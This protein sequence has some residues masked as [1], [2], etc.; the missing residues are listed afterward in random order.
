MTRPAIVI[1][2]LLVALS[3]TRP[4]HAQNA[5]EAAIARGV[6]LRKQGKNAEALT[7]FQR[8]LSMK[9]TPRAQAQV[10]LA[11]QAL[12]AW[13][14][15]EGGLMRALERRDDAWIAHNLEP[16]SAALDLIREHLASVRIETNL[17]GAALFVNGRAVGTSPLIAAVRVVAGE[18]ELLAQ[19][20]GHGDAHTVLRLKAG[21]EQLV[22]LELPALAAAARATPQA[23]RL[24]AATA[25]TNQVAQAAAPTPAANRTDTQL[26]PAASASAS[27][28]STPVAN[29]DAWAPIEPA[30]DADA[31]GHG[32]GMRIGGIVSLS[33]AGLFLAGGIAA[34][35]VYERYATEYN[36]P[37]RCP[38]R[39]DCS[40]VRRA[41]VTAKPLMI[42]GYALAGAALVTA[43]VLLLAAPSDARP[44]A[45]LDWQLAALS[46]GAYAQLTRS[47]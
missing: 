25:A 7:E 15:A 6:A 46:G 9:P 17:N 22:H 28:R 8:A 1:G 40:A 23:T 19:L 42:T 34:H 29:D 44:S 33:A 3:S 35:L 24:A 5:S 37:V 14:E 41:A 13:V 12:G 38:V 21:S 30:P 47:F 2:T 36:D 16:L 27:T 18:V 11:H 39:A 10:A 4:L 32:S 20:P 31:A 26:Q 45:S 43:V